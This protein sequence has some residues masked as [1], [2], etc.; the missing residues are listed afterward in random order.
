MFLCRSIPASKA[1]YQIN[2]PTGSQRCTL[3][4]YSF[5]THQVAFLS[6]RL[7]L[8]SL[9]L[10]SFSLSLL[11][12]ILSHVPSFVSSSSFVPHSCI[13]HLFLFLCFRCSVMSFLYLFSSFF[14]SFWVFYHQ[15]FSSSRHDRPTSRVL[16][17][18]PCRRQKDEN[19]SHSAPEEQFAW[20]HVYGRAGRQIDSPHI[21]QSIPFC[22]TG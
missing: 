7:S 11:H 2:K 6:Y 4:V 15:S 14:L 18:R 19:D 17:S 16:A 10:A 22:G 13:R 3:C 1:R 12:L 20:A 8:V 21:W 5:I 9:Y